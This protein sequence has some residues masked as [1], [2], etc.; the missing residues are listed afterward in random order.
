MST[1]P[2]A[3]QGARRALRVPAMSLGWIV[4]AIGVVCALVLAVP[5]QTITTKYVNDLFIFLDGAY[6]IFE[7]QVPN[8]DFHSSLGPLAFY[9]PAFGYAITGSL[10]AAM[11]LGMGLAT[12]FL[13]AI[14]AHL[15]GTRMRAV[16]GIPLAMFLLLIAAV[17]LNP[18]EGIADLSFAMFYNRLGW[19]A[20][21]LLLVMYLPPQDWSRRQTALDALCAALLTLFLLYLKASYGLVALAFIIFMATDRQSRPWAIAALLAIAAAILLIEPFWRGTLTYFADVQLAR[22]VSGDIPDLVRLVT[23]AL[24]NLADIAV[25]L[26][27]TLL[28]LVVRRRFRDFLFLG[29]VGATGI[30]LIEQNFQIVGILTLAAGASVVAELI[31]RAAPPWARDGIG[32]GLPLLVAIMMVPVTVQNGAALVLHAG[33]A[34][35]Q[36][37]EPITLP[38]YAGVRLAQLSNEGLY[39]N[40]SRYNQSLADGAVALASLDTEVERVVVFDFVGPFSA[41]LGLVPPRDDS[42][43]YHWGR[44]LHD[45][46]FPPADEILADAKIIMEAK[47][48]IEVWTANG[49]RR[50]YAPYLDNNFTLASESADWRIYVRKP[51]STDGRLNTSNVRRQSTSAQP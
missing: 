42:P 22:E 36:K 24:P 4:F 50:V 23:I 19:T 11:P 16:T 15:I 21:G 49:M 10:G 7:G 26:V 39:R 17:S 30:L 45:E 46:V 28:L 25:F 37:G 12:V 40:F 5:G 31:A 32:A 47:A 44:T 41:G 48:P 8:R 20:I 13:A 35:G 33:L 51:S 18:G 6:R 34:L 29:F 43:W 14:G 38:G 2:I 27:F 9:L 3:Q 1:A